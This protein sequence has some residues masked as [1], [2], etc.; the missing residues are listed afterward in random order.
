LLQ[1]AGQ[2]DDLA[3]QV[4]FDFHINGKPVKMENGHVMHYT[5]DFTYTE[6]GQQIVE[7]VKGMI[8]P[9]YRMRRALMKAIYNVKIRET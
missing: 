5:A 9:D 8:T 3:R 2:I 1:K 6:N 7:D 4:W